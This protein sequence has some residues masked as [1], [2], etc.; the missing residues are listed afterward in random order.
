MESQSHG[1][2]FEDKIIEAVVGIKKNEYQNLIENRYTSSMDIVKGIKSKYDYSIKVSKEKSGIGGGD[3][4]R[5]FD[6]S[7]KGFKLIVGVWKQSTS[8]TKTYHTIYEFDIRKTDFEIL[9]NNI[10]RKEICKFVDYVR[11]IPSGKKAQQDNRALWKQKRQK[12]YDTCGKGIVDI[13]AKIDSK[14]Q[15]RVQCSIDIDDLLS[16]GIK[17]IVYQENYKGIKLP[18]EQKSQSRKFKK[19]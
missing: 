17:C 19:T 14:N 1:F 5:F 8:D 15:R 9:W 2:D 16:S 18:Y 4:L 7:L 3:I 13:A 11:N 12:I 10:S 6:H